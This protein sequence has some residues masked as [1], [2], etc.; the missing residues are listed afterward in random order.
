MCD[1]W[2]CSC[3]VATVSWASFEVFRSH[4]SVDSTFAIRCTRLVWTRGQAASSRSG[5][6]R[7]TS[8]EHVGCFPCLALRVDWVFGSAVLLLPLTALLSC[9]APMSSCVTARSMAVCT[10]VTARAPHSAVQSAAYES[11]RYAYLGRDTYSLL[12]SRQSYN[13][14]LSMWPLSL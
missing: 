9:A 5:I 13:S 4:C 10:G 7:G 12:Q 6:G 2:A 3:V 11:A 8:A 14:G 1:G